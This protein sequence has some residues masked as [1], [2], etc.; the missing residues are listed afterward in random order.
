MHELRRFI[1]DQMDARGWTQAD[2][3][4]ASGLSKQL[5]STLYLDDRDRLDAMPSRDTLAA[6]AR[7]FHV[8]VE[9]ISLIAARAY[10]IPVDAPAVVPTLEG[11]PSSELAAELQRRLTQAEQEPAKPARHL[12]A[13]ANTPPDPRKP[14]PRKT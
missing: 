7:A 13:A 9:S 5:V 14:K 2:L 12:R 1:T 10:G 6:L 11:F 4:R 8:A 3:S